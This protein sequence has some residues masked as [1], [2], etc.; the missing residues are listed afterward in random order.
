[1]V[2][3]HQQR[4]V[5]SKGEF[6]ELLRTDKNDAYAHLG[7]GMALAAEQNHRGALQEV[8]TAAEINPD[9][10]SAFYKI[11]L[12]ETKLKQYDEAIAAFR[13]QLENWGDDY[14]TE[15]ALAEAYQAKGMLSEAKDALE[16]A[17]KLKK[18][19]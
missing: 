6:M 7:L 18:E 17:G 14:D 11:G 3:L 9:F 12:E 13:K 10:S 5:E 15:T 2:Y 1:M 19:K 16:K 8:K 4:I